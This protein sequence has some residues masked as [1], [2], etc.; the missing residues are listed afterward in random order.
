MIEIGTNETAWAISATPVAVGERD[1]EDVG[2]GEL[3]R[4]VVAADAAGRGH[5]EAE[6]GRG[7][8]DVRRRERQLRVRRRA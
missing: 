7:R 1:V 4:R 8:D 2:Q 5:R 6:D 3:D